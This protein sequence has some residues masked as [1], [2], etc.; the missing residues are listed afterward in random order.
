[1]SK[2]IGGLRR[3]TR[4]ELSKPA[5]LRGKISIRKYLTEFK[6]GEKVVLKLD[7]ACHE[8]AYHARFMGKIGSVVGKRGACYE[9]KIRDLEKEKIIVSH[10]IHLKRI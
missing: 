1:M 7:P 3:R 2:R 10:P 4:G 8:G 9:V 6:Q 5:R